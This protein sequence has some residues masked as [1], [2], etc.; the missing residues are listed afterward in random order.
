MPSARRETT[1]ESP[2]CEQPGPKFGPPI[3]APIPGK[4]KTGRGR[5]RKRS[6]GEGPTK[7]TG[8]NRVRFKQ[9]YFVRYRK[10]RHEK[11]PDSLLQV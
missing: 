4:T 6:L 7:K 3:A 5:D 2:V 9:N 1:R 10:R 8:K 11:S